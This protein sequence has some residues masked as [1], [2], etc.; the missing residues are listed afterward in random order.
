MVKQNNLKNA[1]SYI[2]DFLT[3]T[4]NK[5]IFKYDETL[6]TSQKAC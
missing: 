1:K 3:H 6:Y 2:F 5:K 4:V